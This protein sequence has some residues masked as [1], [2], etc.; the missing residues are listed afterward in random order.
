MTQSAETQNLGT[1]NPGEQN[2]GTENPGELV[3]QAVERALKFVVTWPAW[4]GEPRVS[5]D[6]R[7]FTPH[8]AVRRIADHMIDHLAEVEALL[9]GVPTQP[10]EW[11]ASSVTSTADLAPFTE[12]DVR[13]AEQRL[14]RLA[15]TFE[16]RYAA[17]D[18]AEWDKDR[19]P[20]WTLRVI[21]EHLIELDWYAE[22]VGD[23]S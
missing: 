12:A 21:A 9:A 3:G 7:I 5:D 6:D 2:P 4:D 18:P 8:K 19:T 11:H 17:L 10:D 13:E 1:Q 23:F 14:R 20:N 15:R 22:Q 16:L